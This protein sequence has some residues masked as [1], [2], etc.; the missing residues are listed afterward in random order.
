MCICKLSK[1]FELTRPNTLPPQIYPKGE[2]TPIRGHGNMARKM[3]LHYDRID[4]S[5]ADSRGD[6]ATV[7]VD[8]LSTTLVKMA[9]RMVEQPTCVIPSAVNDP[10]LEAV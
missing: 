1:V 9:N 2:F 5:A 3:G 8:E 7:P 10:F 6:G 4:I